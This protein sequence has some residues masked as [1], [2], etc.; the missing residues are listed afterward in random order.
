MANVFAQLDTSGD[1]HLD[2]EEFEEAMRILQVKLKRG[3][4]L[5][6]V[7]ATTTLRHLVMNP[8]FFFGSLTHGECTKCTMTCDLMSYVLYLLFHP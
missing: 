5:C 2:E 3:N 7:D 4:A 6:Y 1:G 8:S